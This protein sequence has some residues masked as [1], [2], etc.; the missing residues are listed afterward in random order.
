[1]LRIGATGSFCPLPS[2]GAFRAKL[3]YAQ[4]YSLRPERAFLGRE[5]KSSCSTNPQSCAAMESK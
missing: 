2:S 1:M 4:Y 5:Q 3:M